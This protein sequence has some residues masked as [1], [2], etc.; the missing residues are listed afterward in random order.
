MAGL[1]KR[2]ATEKPFRFPPNTKK[3]ERDNTKCDFENLINDPK[4]PDA[5]SFGGGWSMGITVWV[6]C[7]EMK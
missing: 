3:N 2:N 4:L 5:T 6:R 1:Q 7:L